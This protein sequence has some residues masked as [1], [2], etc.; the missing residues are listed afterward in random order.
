MLRRGIIAWLAIKSR[1]E[2]LI[3]RG[4]FLAA[5]LTVGNPPVAPHQRKTHE[6]I[7]NLLASPLHA[8]VPPIY[9]F[10]VQG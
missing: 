9:L 6:S 3:G 5:I 2:A 4:T 1:L 7:G 8:Q 10:H